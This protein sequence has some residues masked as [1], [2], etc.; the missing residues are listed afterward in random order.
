M[1]TTEDNLKIAE[2]FQQDVG[3]GRAR[4]DDK[5]RKELDISIG[6]AIEIQ[7]T[8]TTAAV[9][10]RA[11]PTDEGKKVI[12]ID[13]LTR[14]NA[15][16]GLGDCVKI[17]RAETRD[18]KEIT[19]APLVSEG[20][21]V[22]FGAGI[23]ALIK[24]GLKERPI[25]KGDSVIIPGIALFGS[26][27]PFVVID[28]SPSG[29]VSIS[30]DTIINV[31][32]EGAGTTEIGVIRVG[33]EDIGGLH[34]EI[35]KI[36]EITELPIKHPGLFDRLG[37][38]MKKGILLHGPSGTGKTLMGKALANECG[39]N[40]YKINGPEIMSKY[41]G[42]TEENLR[43]IFEEA[44]K[45][46]PSIIFIDEIDAITRARTEGRG[47][48]EWR[49]LSQLLTLM[50][51]LAE[52]AR[53]IVI[54]VTDMPGSL[55]PSLRRSGRFDKEIEF[56]VPDTNDRKEI[57][58]I[59]TRFMPLSKD[60]NL[61]QIAESTNDFVGADLAALAEEAALCSLRRYL[62]EINLELPISI[63]VLE[64]MEVTLDD[65][66]NALHNFHRKKQKSS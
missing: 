16:T 15:G 20:Q 3:Y 34:N 58:S 52:N 38:K 43:K 33:Y 51:D 40:F 4:I 45:N 24:K 36:R 22:Q 50:D 1:K 61:D 55:D 27:L 17:K 65:F 5:T 54:G 30:K 29:I 59:H 25:Y 42:Q 57:L 56:K 23:E 12:R 8:K 14:K 19:L 28:T 10:W 49:V 44:K 31:K 32:E 37:I 66:K 46:A 18:A 7:G 62:P 9:V 39:A 41:V 64:K 53:V 13:N 6:D 26:S 48:L 21:Q 11:H 63:E 47:E 60:F 2:A 35:L